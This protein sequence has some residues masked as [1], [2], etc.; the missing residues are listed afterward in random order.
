MPEAETENRNSMKTGAEQDVR[1]TPDP[2]PIGWR[3]GQIAWLGSKIMGQFKSGKMT[4]NRPVGVERSFGIPCCSGCV[5]NLAGVLSGS[6]TCLVL[7]RG[8]LQ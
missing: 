7:V 3:P 5:D 2:R 4:Q 8:F 6:S 1:Q